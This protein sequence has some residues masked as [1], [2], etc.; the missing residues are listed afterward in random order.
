M[1]AATPAV[2]R[3]SS[4]ARIGAT[5]VSARSSAAAPAFWIAS[6][7]PVSMYDF[8]RVS[9][10]ISSLDPTANPMRQPVIEKL[11]DSEKNSTATS[12]APGVSKILGAR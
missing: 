1:S 11:F 6:H 7:G 12:R 3:R 5:S 10:P 4:S 9:A 2:R 8:T